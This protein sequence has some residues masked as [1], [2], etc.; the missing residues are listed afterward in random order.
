MSSP[1]DVQTL[2]ANNGTDTISHNSVEATSL[3]LS[4]EKDI[5]VFKTPYDRT[6]NL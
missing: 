1:T 5:K 6:T 4:N 2:T 3:H